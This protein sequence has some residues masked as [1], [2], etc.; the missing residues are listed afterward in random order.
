[1]SLSTISILSSSTNNRIAKSNFKPIM[2]YRFNLT[3]YSGASYTGNVYDYTSLSYNGANVGVLGANPGSGTA[4]FVRFGSGAFFTNYGGCLNLPTIN[5]TNMKTITINY[6]WSSPDTSFKSM[7]CLNPSS[8]SNYVGTLYITMG[9]ASNIIRLYPGSNSSTYLSYTMPVSYI[10]GAYH[11]LSI[12]VN[13]NNYS[14]IIYM[15]NVYL[16]TFDFS[17][18]SSNFS[19]LNFI[20]CSL[21]KSATNSTSAGRLL[22]IDNLKIYGYQLPTTSISNLFNAID[23]TVLY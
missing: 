11:M 17:S 6:F 13:F 14:V 12:I 8:A 20:N 1:M 18:Y 10:D 7:L 5:M 15:D 2:D 16:T 19:N 21:D 9:S 22:Y 4:G 23:E 3:D